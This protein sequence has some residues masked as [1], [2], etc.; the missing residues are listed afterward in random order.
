MYY[1]YIISNKNNSV[2]YTGVTNDFIRRICEHKNKLV[3]GF[4]KK[5][6]LNKLLYYEIAEDI[7]NGIAR[8]KQI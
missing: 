5:Y 2:F 1:I 8:D 6:N 7:I 4:S 3:N